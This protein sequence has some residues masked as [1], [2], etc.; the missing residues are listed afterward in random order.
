MFGDKI[1]FR[2]HAIKRMFERR[3]TE[4][5]IRQVLLQGQEIE[6]YPNDVPYPSRLM[7]GWVD[8]SPL[9]V[10]AAYNKRDDQTIVITVYHPDRKLWSADF[11]IRSEP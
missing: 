8:N 9:H 3:I 11:R 2:V 7:L 10:I 6:S 5:G 1:I 4:A